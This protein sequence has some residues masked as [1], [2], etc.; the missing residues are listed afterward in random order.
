ME[1]PAPLEID[2]APAYLV[3]EILDSS[4]RGGQLK[5][6][7]DWEGYRPQESLWVAIRDIL[8]ASLIHE[9]HLK[10]HLDQG[11]AL[12]EEHR[13]VFVDEKIL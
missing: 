10:Q 1:P 11:D 13:E 4:R 9:F 7:V 8:D 3:R 12:G 5:N 2:G 6:L